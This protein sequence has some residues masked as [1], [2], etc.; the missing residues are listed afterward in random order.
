MF[1][2]FRCPGVTDDFSLEVYAGI[3][4]QVSQ[5]VHTSVADLSQY[6]FLLKALIVHKNSCC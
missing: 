3:E 6:L 1:T 4:S 2:E 5:L